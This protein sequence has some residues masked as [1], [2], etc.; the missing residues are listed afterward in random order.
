MSH[1][2]APLSAAARCVR[3]Y[4]LTT[5]ASG[6]ANRQR[7]SLGGVMRARFVC[8]R[9]VGSQVLSFWRLRNREGGVSGVASFGTR[10]RFALGLLC[11]FSAFLLAPLTSTP[12]MGATSPFC[13]LLFALSSHFFLLL[14]MP[15]FLRNF[16][17]P[18]P[19]PL[20]LFPLE[21][22]VL[23]SFA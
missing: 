16:C 5:G 17:F 15:P 3:R 13:F 11:S 8:Q 23:S 1:A 22:G 7:G 19:M 2:T 21:I 12:S 10:L 9:C 14:S 6:I 18:L 20:P 4:A